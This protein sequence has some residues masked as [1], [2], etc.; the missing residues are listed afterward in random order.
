M[1]TVQT[2]GS[3]LT[4]DGHKVYLESDEC[5]FGMSDRAAINEM[6]FNGVL[7]RAPAA[8]TVTSMLVY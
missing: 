8:P 5:F 7:P 6:P 1:L 3:Q 4:T 2:N